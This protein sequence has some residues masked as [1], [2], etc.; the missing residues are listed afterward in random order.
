[1]QAWFC[2]KCFAFVNQTPKSIFMHGSGMQFLDAIQGQN[3]IK[4]FM[5]FTVT[6]VAIDMSS[7]S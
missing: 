3:V 6:K 5:K 4:T 1:M 7:G 2:V